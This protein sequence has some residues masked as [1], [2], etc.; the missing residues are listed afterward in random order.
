MNKTEFDN[1]ILYGP[2]H[3]YLHEIASEYMPYGLHILGEQMDD[4]GI[5]AMVK[6]MLGGTFE[7]HIAAANLCEDPHYLDPAHS[8]NLLDELL[9]ESDGSA[10]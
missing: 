8:P 9:D 3:D 2:V 4:E 5:I 1:F 7:E 6:S 10:N